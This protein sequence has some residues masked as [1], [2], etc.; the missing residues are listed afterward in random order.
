MGPHGPIDEGLSAPMGGLQQQVRGGVF[1]SQSCTRTH[2]QALVRPSQHLDKPA[3][4]TVFRVLQA[5]TAGSGKRGGG[6]G[7]GEGGGG[8]GG[9]GRGGSGRG[10]CLRSLQM[11]QSLLEAQAEAD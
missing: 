3:I 8:G 2:R 11:L 5:K 1:C 10:G 6:G 7:G 4:H 9:G